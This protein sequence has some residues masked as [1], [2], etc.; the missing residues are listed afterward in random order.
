MAALGASALVEADARRSRSR[1]GRLVNT[2]LGAGVIAGAANLINLL[3]LRPGR[4]LKVGLITSAPLLGG[5]AGGLLAGPIG[6]SAVL[7]PA[8]LDEEVMLGDT[9]ANSLG[10][11]IGLSVVAR[12]GP[13]GRAAVL[14]GL[15]ALTVA[16]EKVSF[17]KV[18]ESTPGLREF[19]GL[20]R[21]TDHA[22]SRPDAV[23]DSTE[24][25]IPG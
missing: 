5:G 3:D 1:F 16:S 23:R 14:A 17:T 8:D 4:A 11:L 18:I 13:A 12:T 19:D 24:P 15:A 21:R 2:L 6:A 25:Q 22:D 7:L 20:G 10:A 9:G